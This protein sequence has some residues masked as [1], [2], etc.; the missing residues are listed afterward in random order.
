M[1][2]HLQ[3]VQ[4]SLQHHH[5]D[6]ILVSSLPNIIYLTGFSGF[7]KEDRDAFLL[8]TKS[9]KYIFTHGIYKEEAEKEMADFTLINMSRGQPI[10]ASLKELIEKQRINKL[11]FEA[12]DLTVREYDHITK[13]LDEVIFK[14]TNLI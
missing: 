9:D 5:L 4:T 12:F 8:I 2:N 1:E 3:A 13:N 11:G 6:A 10:S 7:T 14:P